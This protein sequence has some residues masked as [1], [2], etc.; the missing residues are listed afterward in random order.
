MRVHL[1]RAP[2]QEQL[3]FRKPGY[4]DEWFTANELRV[5]PWMDVAARGWVL[6]AE[7][8]RLFLT[9]WRSLLLALAAA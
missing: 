8:R 5:I 1:T 2:A 4:P 6:L 9:R 7:Q 3:V